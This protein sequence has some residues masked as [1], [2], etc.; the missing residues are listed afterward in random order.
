MLDNSSSNGWYEWWQM[1]DK[2]EKTI[3]WE[4]CTTEMHMKGWYQVKNLDFTWMTLIYNN[5]N[6]DIYVRN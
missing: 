3:W 6:N 5:N 4:L 2:L 1:L